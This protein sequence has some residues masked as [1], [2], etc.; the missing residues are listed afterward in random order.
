MNE[1]F[2]KIGLTENEAL[3]LFEFLSRFSDSDELSIEDQAEQ[4]VLLDIYC[5]LEKSLVAPFD[6]KFKNLVS[7]ARD[8]VRDNID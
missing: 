3:V 7:L 8:A 2:I 1:A 6:P 4:R 5:M